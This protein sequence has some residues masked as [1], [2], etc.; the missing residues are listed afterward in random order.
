MG[1]SLT[2]KV[3]EY[4]INILIGTFF[5]F[6]NGYAQES[7][8]TN[9][10]PMYGSVQRT[11]EEKQADDEFIRAGIKGAGSREAAA[12]D[13][14]MVGWEFVGEG[15]LKTAMKRFNQAWL[16]T[17]NSA[18]VFFGF[19]HI[20]LQQGQSDKAKEMLDKAKLLNSNLAELYYNRGYSYIRRGKFPDKAIEDFNKAIEINPDYSIAYNDRGN[21]FMAK[22]NTEQAISDYNKAL[23]INPNFANPYYNLGLFYGDKGDYDKAISNYNKALE[24]DTKHYAAYINRAI[25]YYFKKEYD[26]SWEDVHKVEESGVKIHPEFLRKLKE[27]SGR[28]K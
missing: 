28:E 4:G 19:S 1:P 7:I 24:I 26:K 11:V 2:K 6:G 8:P 14:I 21:A 20:L 10:L 17:P 15:D 3:K 27:D 9:E 18:D 22:G 13:M 12:K 16:L 5:V 25:A 23:E